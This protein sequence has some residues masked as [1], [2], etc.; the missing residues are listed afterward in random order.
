[1]NV[2][3]QTG[4]FGGG[5]YPA[6][7][8]VVRILDFSLPAGCHMIDGKLYRMVYDPQELETIRFLDGSRPTACALVLVSDTESMEPLRRSI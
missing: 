5:N 4:H 6:V 1:M 7:P 2:I 8:V 3:E